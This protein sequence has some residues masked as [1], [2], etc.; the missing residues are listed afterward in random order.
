MYILPPKATIDE[1][2]AN[3]HELFNGNKKGVKEIGQLFTSYKLVDILMKNKS[4]VNELRERNS[5]LLIKTQE[6]LKQMNSLKDMT[7]KKN[8]LYEQQ[9]WSETRLS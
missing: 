4:F 7:A 1:Y 3:L 6:A 2:I 8:K 9:D 5:K